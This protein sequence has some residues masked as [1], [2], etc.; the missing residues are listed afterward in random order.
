MEIVEIL[1]IVEVFGKLDQSIKSSDFQSWHRRKVQ[2]LNKTF[3]ITIGLCRLLK[4]ARS[5]GYKFNLCSFWVDGTS[6]PCHEWNLH[7]PIT[8]AIIIIFNFVLM[9]KY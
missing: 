8:G 6:F 4:S 3:S 1:S 5:N 7:C 9:F 2:Q